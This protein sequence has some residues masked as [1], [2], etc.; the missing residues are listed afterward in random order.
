MCLRGTRQFGPKDSTE[1]SAHPSCVALYEVKSYP[2][3]RVIGQ[4]LT[5]ELMPSF[6]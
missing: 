1:H 4:M 3:L 6:F 5:G 2:K